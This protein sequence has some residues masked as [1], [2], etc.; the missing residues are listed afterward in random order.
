MFV[1]NK[2]CVV[3]IKLISPS[4]K[5][6]EIYSWNETDLDEKKTK[7]LKDINCP[8]SGIFKSVSFQDLLKCVVHV[9]ETD[10]KRTKEQS[11]KVVYSECVSLC[12]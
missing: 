6:C 11:I 8:I 7:F 10:I 1:V 12:I 9:I 3:K 5:Q 2:D 4:K